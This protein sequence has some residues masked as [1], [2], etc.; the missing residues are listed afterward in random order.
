MGDS[1][2]AFI[3]IC[4]VIESS[5]AGVAILPNARVYALIPKPLYSLAIHFVNVMFPDFAMEYGKPPTRPEIAGV[6]DI[7]IITPP[8][9]PTFCYVTTLTVIR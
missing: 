6:E 3:I 4:S 7:L 9:L 2:A 5:V 8:D 1:R